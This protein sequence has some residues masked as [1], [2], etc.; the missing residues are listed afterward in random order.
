MPLTAEQKTEI[1]AVK[2]RLA[3]KLN[4]TRNLKY[5]LR[6]VINCA[7]GI[8]EDEPQDSDLGIA[9]SAR[10]LEALRVHVIAKGGMLAPASR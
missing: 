6:D 10:R 7:N 3:T 8:L 4:E 9:L 1:E 2:T 5:Q